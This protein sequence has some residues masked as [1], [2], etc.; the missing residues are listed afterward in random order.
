MLL[1]QAPTAAHCLNLKVI[2]REETISRGE[3]LLRTLNVARTNL[4]FSF[5]IQFQAQIR[6]SDLQHGRP[7]VG[8]QF[9]E[10]EVRCMVLTGLNVDHFL[11]PATLIPVEALKAPLLFPKDLLPIVSRF[12]VHF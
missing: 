1:R 2:I 11:D 10:L 8:A 9:F 6:R 5:P 3:I 7:E 4:D 12:P